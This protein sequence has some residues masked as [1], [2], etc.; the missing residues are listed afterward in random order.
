MDKSA[1]LVYNVNFIYV[2]LSLKSSYLAKQ[3]EYVFR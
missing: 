3:T 2:K 1:Y